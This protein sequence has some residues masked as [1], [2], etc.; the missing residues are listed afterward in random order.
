LLVGLV[1]LLWCLIVAVSSPERVQTQVPVTDTERYKTHRERQGEIVCVW[2]EGGE[3]DV[4]SG[5]GGFSGKS[6]L[7]FQLL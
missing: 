2:V 4:G 7:F 6:I 3:G 5:G 1:R